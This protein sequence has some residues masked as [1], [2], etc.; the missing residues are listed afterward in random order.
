MEE[1]CKFDFVDYKGL[2]IIAQKLL[3]TVPP[4]MILNKYAGY[5]KESSVK[6]RVSTVGAAVCVVWQCGSVVVRCAH[7]TKKDDSTFLPS[8]A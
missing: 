3:W 7:P 5:S 8:T 2:F 1:L 4:P 6:E